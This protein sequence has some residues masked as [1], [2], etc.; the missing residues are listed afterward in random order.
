MAATIVALSTPRGVG[1]LAV[2]RVSGAGAQAVVRRLMSLRRKPFSER[3]PFLAELAWKGRTL[4]RALVTFFPSPRSFTGEDCVEISCHGSPWLADSI[5][6]ALVEAGARPAEPG[7]FSLRAFENGKLDLAQAEALDDLIRARTAYAAQAAELQIEGGLSREVKGVRNLLIEIMG[8]LDAAVDFVEEGQ[9]FGPVGESLENLEGKLAAMRDSYER[10]RLLREGARVALVGPP[11]AGKS[12]LFNALVGSARAI[13]TDVPGTTRD[14]VDA[15]LDWDGLEVTLRD[16]AG[17]RRA[18]GRVEREGVRRSAQAI[19]EADL[20]LVVLDG[21]KKRLPEE[22]RALLRKT[23]ARRCLV[24]RNKC[25]LAAHAAPGMPEDALAVSARTG[26]GMD[27]LRRRVFRLL[28]GEA[29]RAGEILLTRARHRDLTQRALDAV[30]ASRRALGE[31]AGEEI[32][33]AELRR[34]A[35]ALAEITG[36]IAPDDVLQYIF[37]T[38]CIGK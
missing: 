33:S 19:E 8:R 4:D 6:A 21:S 14:V 27:E 18:R 10:G 5:L 30:R 15:A 24:L 13:V 36:E 26:E 23:S 22:T 37:G 35:G 12:S 7:E 20:L 11:N 17:I 32:V 31:R 3:R 29:P 2:I 9:D 38:F 16:T 25:D 28:L 1:A 34:A